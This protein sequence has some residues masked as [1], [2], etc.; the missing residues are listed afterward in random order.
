MP[1]SRIEQRA[2]IY[3]FEA[4]TGFLDLLGGYLWRLDP[5]ILKAFVGASGV[6]HSISPLDPENLAIGYD[7]GAKGVLELWL[8]IGDD[9]WSSLDLSWSSAHE[10][11]SAR[12]RIGYRFTKQLSFGVEGRFDID[13]QGD[14]DIRWKENDSCKRQYRNQFGTATDVFDYSRGGVFARYEWVGGEIS[15]AV[16]VSGRMLGRGVEEPDPYGSVSWIT[17]W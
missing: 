17:Q 4:Q 7:W 2:N 8:N 6:G 1:R 14:C 10:T 11:R 16:G 13:A 5:L 15:A 9:M 12:G 3:K